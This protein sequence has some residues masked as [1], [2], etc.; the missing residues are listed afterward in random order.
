MR[1][2]FVVLFFISLNFSSQSQGLL[3]SK[4]V[5]SS[6]SLPSLLASAKKVAILPFKVAISYKKMPKGLSTEQI[7]E[8]EKQESFQLQQGMY[9][10]LLRKSNEYTVSFQDV[11]KTNALLK[12]SGITDSF[13]EILADSICKILG[14]DAIIKSTW[15][16]SKTGSEAGAIAT[17]V[18]LGGLKSTASGL[19]I[20]Q[21][22]GAKDGEMAWRMSKE[23]DESAFSSANELMERMMRK[24]GRNFPFER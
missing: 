20:M 11:D 5:F 24:V 13:D 21:L 15:N 19:L 8:N 1:Q 22:H 16:Y 14:V 3:G 18:L 4:Q 10:Y 6:P 23:M 17:A 7:R 12:K 2:F 9:T